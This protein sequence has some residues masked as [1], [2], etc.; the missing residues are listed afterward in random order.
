MLIMLCS[1]YDDFSVVSSISKFP[2]TCATIRAVLYILAVRTA[3]WCSH[4]P[5]SRCALSLPSTLCLSNNLIVK[6][7][8][9]PPFLQ[10]GTYVVLESD[11]LS[12]QQVKS[13]RGFSQSAPLLFP[14]S[15]LLW[16]L[17]LCHDVHTE[18][19]QQQAGGVF[20]QG[21]LPKTLCCNF[22]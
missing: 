21:F 13:S 14:L 8:K 1:K 9:L 11:S 22:P 4:F 3:N 12:C 16:S 18:N 15:L 7:T 17:W 20:I 10:F 19:T 5:I 2:L 6:I